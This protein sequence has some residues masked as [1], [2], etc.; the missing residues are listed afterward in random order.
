MAWGWEAVYWTPVSTKKCGELMLRAGPWLERSTLNRRDQLRKS[1]F[2]AVLFETSFQSDGKHLFSPSG[3]GPGE[4]ALERHILFVYGIQGPYGRV[5]SQD[6][7]PQI[8]LI[9]I[10]LSFI[11]GR[12]K[13]HLYLFLYTV[14]FFILWSKEQLIL[15]VCQYSVVSCHLWSDYYI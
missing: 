15:Y 10:L 2:P 11:I 6:K 14:I 12:R 8:I 3:K 1:F 9:I 4:R 5:S 13:T 7:N